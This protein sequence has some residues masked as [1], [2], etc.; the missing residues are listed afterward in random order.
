MTTPVFNSTKS[1]EVVLYIATRLH[2]KDFHKIFKIIYFADREHMTKYGRSITGDTYI[3]MKD[4]PVPSKID[5]ILK[6]V[7]GDSYFAKDANVVELSKVLSVHDWYFV[8]P[9][10]DANVDLLSQS[11]IDELDASLQKYGSLSWDEVREKSH[12]Y[13]WRTTARDR[14]IS[15]ED[16]M[17]EN[18][19]D[20]D[21]INYVVET[22]Q[23]GK[24]LAHE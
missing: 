8:T 22:T 23:A 11:D 4:G 2:R 21:F 24:E 13:A 18:G 6:A 7:R 17:R 10:R 5:D 14:Q 20:E 16:I 3:A 19:S 15:M 1:M 9:K 12:D